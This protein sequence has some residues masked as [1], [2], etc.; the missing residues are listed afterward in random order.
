QGPSAVNRDA[1]RRDLGEP[2][3]V[4]RLGEDR[5]GQIL[6]DLRRV[7]VEGGGKLDV[8]D[9][10]SAEADMHQPGDG[11]GLAR[12]LVEGHALYQRGRAVPDPDDGDANLPIA[13][14]QPR[15]A[16]RQDGPDRVL[17][18]RPSSQKPGSAVAAGS[19]RA[20]TRLLA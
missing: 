15:S 6:A 3:G 5:F 12:G 14:W 1:Q 13:Q 4:V 2:A 9:V 11:L 10:I 18:F 20:A 17:P 16:G 8:P 7:D 19:I